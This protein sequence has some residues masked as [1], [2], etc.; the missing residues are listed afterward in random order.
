MIPGPGGLDYEGGAGVLCKDEKMRD[1]GLFGCQQHICEI[2]GTL[3]ERHTG[4]LLPNT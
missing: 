3:L 1:W 2:Q 4:V